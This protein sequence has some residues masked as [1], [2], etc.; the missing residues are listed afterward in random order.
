[1]TR[2][3]IKINPKLCSNVLESLSINN[4]PQGIL[5]SLRSFIDKI[6]FLALMILLLKAEVIKLFEG[7]D[8]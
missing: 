8:V 6:I 7:Y 3:R 4:V 5:I 2:R 1:M